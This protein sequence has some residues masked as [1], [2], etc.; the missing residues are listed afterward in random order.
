MIIVFSN[1]KIIK[2]DWLTS[3]EKMIKVFSY[4]PD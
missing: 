4:N 2:V 1:D 3:E